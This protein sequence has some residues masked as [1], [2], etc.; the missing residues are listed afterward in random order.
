[1]DI[2]NHPEFVAFL[3][4]IPRTEIA[5]HG[6]H[7]INRGYSVSA[8]F[9]YQERATCASMLTQ[10]IQIFEESG[11]RYVR[12]LQPPGWNCG[13]ELQQACRDVGTEWVASARDIQTPVCRR[14][15][16]RR[17]QD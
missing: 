14:T 3:N 12:G 11:L 6:L 15:L 17:C 13:L 16:R 8:E 2:R 4:S 1:M 7:H 10:A 5:I 9:Q